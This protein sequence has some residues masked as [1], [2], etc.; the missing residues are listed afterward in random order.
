[1]LNVNNNSVSHF[2][3]ESFFGFHLKEKH[4]FS[5]FMSPFYGWGSTTLTLQSHYE[6]AVD[7]LPQSFQN[8]LVLIDPEAWKTESVLEPSS[9]FKH[10][11]AGLGIQRFNH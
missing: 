6:E 4:F 7:F 1:M 11:T 2:K 10:D 5:G 8:F 9:G 3:S